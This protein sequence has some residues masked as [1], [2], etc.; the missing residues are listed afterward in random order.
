MKSSNKKENNIK[1]LKWV[2]KNCKRYLPN[3]VII[4][5]F[6]AIVSLSFVALALVSKDVLDIATGAKSGRLLYAGT[7][8][9]GIIALQIFLNIV[10][11]L[12]K[13][14]TTQKIT[15]SL[16]EKLFTVIGRRKYSEISGYHSGDLLTRATADT[17]VVTSGVVG[18]I[19]SVTSML[20][21]L[22]GG[23]T[24]MLVLD[25]RVAVIILVFGVAV[26]AIGRTISKRFKNIHKECQ[27]T[28]SK[29]RS[30]MQECF[31]NIVVLKAFEGEA[32]FVK[33]LNQYMQNN[34]RLIMKRSKISVFIN[35]S[36]YTFFTIGYY[37]ILLWGAGQIALG[38]I[39]Y[40]TLMA[41]LQLVQ[42]LRAPL[43]NVSGILPQYYSALASAERLIEL[44]NGSMDEKSNKEALDKIK[45]GF[46]GIELKNIVFG[47]K[48]ETVLDN[49]SID[50]EPNKITAITGESGSGKS[51][52]F[53]ILLG[54]YEP[55]QG[56]IR[57]NGEYKLDTSL[58]G[59]FAYVPQGNLILSGT[60]RENLTI[61]NDNVS[62]EELIAAAKAAEIY[63]IIAEL[64]QG[65]D[66]LLSERGAGLSE[67]QLQRISIARALLT[68]AP[69]LLL[70]EATSALDEATETKVLN[71][72]KN[73]KNKTV[74]FVT[75]R[76]TSLRVCD[77]IVHI[78][79]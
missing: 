29:T 53:K 13:T 41:F 57:V 52:I 1:T 79:D 68:D 9:F 61:C 30:F 65:F 27:K 24:T 78:G 54:L 21:K 69:V 66:T 28:E 19:P 4:A 47:Y 45:N 23:I 77:N 22:V 36:L 11:T 62:Q 31:E 38:A 18:I 5:L 74:I 6:S 3:V 48:D 49:I 10:D 12:L 75:H 16:R 64:P 39:T 33:K 55:K 2:L 71:N 73:L 51:T 56:E 7:L 14:Y 43:Q 26:P 8:L 46:E 20:A 70:D 34:F 67:G 63:D 60:L 76:N 25:R 32:T 72:I 37:A 17:D 58:R 44:E 15:M 50:I 35:M 59:I 42:Q 40:G